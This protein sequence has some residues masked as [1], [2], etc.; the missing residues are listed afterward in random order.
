[1]SNR[2]ALL[3]LPLVFACGED[4]PSSSD[5][6][7]AQRIAAL[8]S[9]VAALEAE[10]TSQ[11]DAITALEAERDVLTAAAE[12]NASDIAAMNTDLSNYVTEDWVESQNY[13]ASDEL[14]GYATELW[15]ETQGFL[16][17]SDLAGYATES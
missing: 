1:M 3:S 11:A 12:Q 15:V 5:D 2:I 7:F 10:N 9:T 17:G 14:T 8:E 16:V 6:L 4:S 13:I